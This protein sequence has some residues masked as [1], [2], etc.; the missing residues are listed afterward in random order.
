MK[1]KLINVPSLYPDFTPY[2]TKYG[3]NADAYSKKE[4]KEYFDY[5]KL[6]SSNFWLDFLQIK[7]EM[8]IR[9]KLGSYKSI[10]YLAR[11]IRRSLPI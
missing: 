1:T 6:N 10:Y 3:D 11:S 7:S 8:F 9:S 2:V 4:L 5:Y